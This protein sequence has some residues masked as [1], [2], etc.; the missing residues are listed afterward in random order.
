VKLERSDSKKPVMDGPELQQAPK[1]RRLRSKGSVA[2]LPNTGSGAVASIQQVVPSVPLSI[3]TSQ[4]GGVGTALSQAKLEQEIA[5]GVALRADSAKPAQAA[6]KAEAADPGHPASQAKREA[7]AALEPSLVQPSLAPSLIMKDDPLP[8][9][10]VKSSRERGMPDVGD[11]AVTAAA[12]APPPPP[13][14]VQHPTG[15]WLGSLG[16]RS[17]LTTKQEDE[18]TVHVDGVDVPRAAWRPV[19]DPVVRR[20]AAEPSNAV[21]RKAAGEPQGPRSSRA[22]RNYKLFSKA[23]GQ[24]AAP[25]AAR[26][27]VSVWTPATERPLGE[28]FGTQVFDSQGELPPLNL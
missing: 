12:V 22:T 5:A 18:A 25:R 15:V 27:V 16:D 13:Q 3:S 19:A 11:V 2:T 21:S 23:P 9:A 4:G 26:V 10:Q 8:N 17:L 6:V 1:E 20:L 14:P 28:L 24:R 7:P